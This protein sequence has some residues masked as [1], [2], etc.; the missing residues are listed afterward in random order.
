MRIE[1]LAVHAGHEVD[2][3]SGAVTPPIFLSTTYAREADGSY[4]AGFVY[5]R[6]A[7]PNRGALERCLAVLE[8]GVCAA[9]FSSGSA[10]TMTLLQALGAG[11]HVVLP[12]DAYFGSIK[13]AREVFGPWGVEVSTID[14]TDLDVVRQAMRP[15]TKLVWVETPSNPLLRIVDVAAIAKIAHDAGAV[16]AVDN[17]WGTPVLQRPLDLGADISMHSTTKY[18]AG[19]SDVL[20]GA[21]IFRQDDDLCKRVLMIQGTGGAVPSP[22]EC[23]LAM[24][25]LRSMPLRVRAQSATAGALAEFLVAQPRVERVHYPGLTSHAGHAIAARQMSGFGGML[26]VQVGESAEE[27]IAVAS[28]LKLFT[29]ATSLGGT[30][31]L[32]EHRASV[33]GAAT[34]SPHNLLR[35]SVGLE[36]IDDLKADFEQALRG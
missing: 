20:G 3:A 12:D 2:P 36:H 30:E 21:L 18:I 27:S 29:Q 31:S 5:S 15:N 4:R 11:A 34:Q 1:T 19:H 32:I 35:V 25:G 17:T 23:W 6:Y 8:G 9:A 22:F 24:R 7:N 28:A 14:M 33:E 13:L 16:C 10:A 26:S